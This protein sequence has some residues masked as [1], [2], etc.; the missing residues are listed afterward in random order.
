MDGTSDPA[1]TNRD[2]GRQTSVF[3]RDVDRLPADSTFGAP[4]CHMEMQYMA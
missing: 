4:G 3:L 1:S 2:T